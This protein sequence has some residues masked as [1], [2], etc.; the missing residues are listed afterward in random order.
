[1]ERAFLYLL[2]GAVGA[3]AFWM[4]IPEKTYIL[5]S[6]AF[7]YAVAMITFIMDWV[8]SSLEK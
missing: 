6:F 2:V 7:G 8:K 1:M 4:L 3:T 5:W